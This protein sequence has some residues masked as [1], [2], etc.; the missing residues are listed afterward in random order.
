M[1]KSI[2][3]QNLEVVKYSLEEVVKLMQEYI[4]ID[5]EELRTNEDKKMLEH[6]SYM[7]AYRQG[8]KA[9]TQIALDLLNQAL[10]GE[11]IK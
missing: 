7:L 10:R 3:E 9:S 2:L 8:Q 1:K 4:E 11:L 5:E 6:Y